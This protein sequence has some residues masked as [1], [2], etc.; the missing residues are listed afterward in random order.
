MDFERH[1]KMMTL[2][3]EQAR[4]SQ[5]EGGV[6][7]GAVLVKSDK[8]IST[9]YNRRV[10]DNDPTA[11]GEIDCIRNAGRKDSYTDMT[12]YTTLSPCKMCSG[13]ILQFNIGQVVVGERQN[14][15]GNISLLEKHGVNVALLSDDR[16]INMMSTFIS[17]NPDLWKE[18]IAA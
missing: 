14:F 11:H 15:K 2:A 5:S 3:L 13:A 1:K 18:D 10:Q 12:L 17:E 9:G 8:V 4:T 16:C 6:P 7:I